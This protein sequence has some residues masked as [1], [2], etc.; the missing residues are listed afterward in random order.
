MHHLCGCEAYKLTDLA[1]GV[2]RNHRFWH[3]LVEDQQRLVVP[4][5]WLCAGRGDATRALDVLRQTRRQ[6]SLFPQL[7]HSTLNNGFIGR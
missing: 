2:V 7:A 1:I 3:A 5:L 4:T 6:S